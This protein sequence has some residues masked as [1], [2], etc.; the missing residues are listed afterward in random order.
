[1]KKKIVLF[2]LIIIF[3]YSL[4]GII[5]IQYT[6]EDKSPIITEI[7]TIEEYQ[8]TLNSNASEYY[9]QEFEILKEN[10]KENQNE[11]EYIKSISKLYIIDLYTLDTKINKY[12]ISTE[13]IYPEIIENYKLNLQD[14]LYKYLEDKTLNERTQELPIVTN[15]N[16]EKIE[17]STYLLNNEKISCKK[18]SLNWT[19]EKDLGYE[20]S[21]TITLIKQD[22]YYYIVEYK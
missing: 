9:K 22:N 2:I 11:E 7:D 8:Y 3:I 10:L 19:Y 21:G 4:G 20:T 13:F 16:I 17:D 14:T 6:K 1:M 12:D 5:Y 15:V 18:V